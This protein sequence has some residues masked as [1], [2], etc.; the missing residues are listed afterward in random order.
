MGYYNR[1]EI[2]VST[3]I[4]DNK[5]YTKTEL[6]AITDAILREH[7]RTELCRECGAEG[8]ETG[9]VSSVAQEEDGKPLVNEQGQP[10]IVQFKEYKCKDEGHIWY[11]GEGKM[12]GIGGNDPI[13]F[14]EHFQAR[15]RR[16]I[17]TS[18][19]TPDPSIVQGQ[20]NRTHPQGRKVN[21]AEQRK[22]NGAS[23]YR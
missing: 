10:L 22:K 3:E 16:E 14:E 2:E 20:Y 7:S 13:L 15:R 8:V 18:L 23:Y 17:Y 19:G 9:N 6:N 1:D 12:R 5:K 11:E 4:D 21:S